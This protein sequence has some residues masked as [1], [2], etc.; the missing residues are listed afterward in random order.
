[1]SNGGQ[2]K[3]LLKIDRPF[4]IIVDE[5]VKVIEETIWDITFQNVL[6]VVGR[7]WNNYQF[8][9]FMGCNPEVLKPK[10]YDAYIRNRNL[11]YVCCSRPRKRLVLFITVPVEGE[12]LSYLQNVFGTENICLYSEFMNEKIIQVRFAYRVW[13]VHQL[14]NHINKK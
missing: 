11:F 13:W 12:F 6:W 10:N 14:L 1:M 3:S 4:D 2:A 7:G 8:D 5:C 9:K